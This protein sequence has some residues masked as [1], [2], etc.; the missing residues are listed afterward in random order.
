MGILRSFSIFCAVAILAWW[1]SPASACS[2]PCGGPAAALAAGS[3]DVAIPLGADQGNSLVF[4]SISDFPYQVGF[5]GSGNGPSGTLEEFV[6]TGGAFGFGSSDL[7]F[8]FGINI[9]SDN[10]ATMV[11]TGFTGYQVSVLSCGNID[12]SQC[13]SGAVPTAS[14]SPN[15]DVIT[16]TWSPGLV[17]ESSIVTLY[18][19]ATT[20]SDPLISLFD[21]A[22][23]SS[24]VD[25][26]FAPSP[27]P[28]PATWTMML[29][30]LAG[31]G[32]AG[33]VQTKRA[34]PAAA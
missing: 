18:T 27:T 29:I 7:S 20:G 14:R 13:T 12:P 23:N 9:T 25:D 22:G 10:L 1:A 21:T 30:G 8:S 3:S 17:G 34:V 24:T 19:T 5:G 15:G 11:I 16:L 6:E 2:A 33:F 4:P 31:F 32:F 26:F 28:L